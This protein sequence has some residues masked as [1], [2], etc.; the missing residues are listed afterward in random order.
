MR[1]RTLLLLRWLAIAGQLIAL[2]IAIKWLDIELRLDLCLIAIGTSVVVNVITS[3]ILPENI[4]LVERTAVPMLAYDF[5]QL[6]ALLYLTGGLSNPFSMLLLTPVIVSA[7]SLGLR[8]TSMLGIMFI[9][10]STLLM[11]FYIPLSTTSGT[12]IELPRILIYGMWFALLTSALFLA[13]YARR[14]TAEAALMSEALLA[15]QTALARE[16]RLTALGGLVAAAAHELGTPL[17]T[18][19]LVATEM[20]EELS[21]QPELCQDAEL[22]RDQAARCRDIMHDMGRSGKDD[23][24]LHHA[25][26]SAVIEEAS[27]PHIDRGKRIITRINGMVINEIPPDQPAIPRHSEIIH[28][29]RNLVQNAVDFSENTVWID[30]TWN[31]DDLHINVGDDGPGYPPE[32]IGK[33]GDPYLSMR[34]DTDIERPEYKGMGLGLFIAKTLLERTGARLAFLN[35]SN[36]QGHVFRPPL[37][38]IEVAQ[39]PGAIVTVVWKRSDLVADKALI[40]RPLGEN[41]KFS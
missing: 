37:G 22:I 13:T 7:A 21:D 17:A 20:V 39:P 1:L 25:P 18:I 30:I 5:A 27:E 3:I 19:K 11:W 24:Y 32:L 29:L 26:V 2:L 35:G 28:G 38:P 8:A 31:R 6:C 40:R 33:I 4:R 41:P 15:T 12:L 34:P 9:G 16:Q 14:I 23:I 10:G 36:V